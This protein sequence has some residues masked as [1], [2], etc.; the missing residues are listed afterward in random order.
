M[1]KDK[2]QGDLQKAMIAKDELRLSTLRMLK[3]GIQYFEIA[4]SLPAGRR[5]GAGYEA[6]DEDVIEVI[7]REIKKRK[8]SIELYKKGGREE[9][10]QN[11]QKEIEILQNY[12]PEQISEEEVRKLIKETISQTGAST[13]ADIGKVMG[14]LMPKVKGKADS[15]LVSNLVRTALSS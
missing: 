8:E 9:L 2:I 13:I 7:G 3:S 12:L 4:K 5:G 1:L 14:T 10:A 6:T 15:T 11:E